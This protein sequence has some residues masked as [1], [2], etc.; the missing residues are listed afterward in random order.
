MGTKTEVDKNNKKIYDRLVKTDPDKAAKFHDNLMKIRKEEVEQIDELK[1]STLSSYVNKAAHQVRAKSG[2]AASFETQGERKRDPENKAAYMNVAQ[3]YRK[4]ARKRLAGIEKATAK[5]AKEEVGADKRDKGYKM[6]SIVR[7][8][9]KK[10]DAQSKGQGKMRPQAGTLAAKKMSEDVEL[11]YIEEKLTAADPASKW[12]SDFVAS[13]N[14]KFAGKS[15]K[16][17]IN[18]ALGAYYSAKRGK[19]EE[20]SIEESKAEG[21]KEARK[22]GEKREDILQG[23]VNKINMTP[24]LDQ[25]INGVK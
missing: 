24:E 9:Q 4:G 16:E 7:A 8:A 19:N 21:K 25:K 10:F 23:K 17:R 3:D 5:L 6:S 1:K 12:I 14:P 11:Q 15:K 22:S 13:D 2:I 20:V 18:M